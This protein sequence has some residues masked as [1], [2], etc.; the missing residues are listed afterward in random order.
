MNLRLAALAALPLLGSLS[1]G[2]F[3]RSYRPDPGPY[4]RI[5]EEAEAELVEA[6]SAFE[7]GELLDARAR[8]AALSERHPRCI[9]VGV[10]LQE[11][12]LLLLERGESVK[13]VSAP[14]AEEAQRALGDVYIARA[15]AEPTPA[16]EVLAA[17]LELDPVEALA[18]LATVLEL[19]RDCVWAHYATAH[20][21]ARLR[22]FPEARAALKAAFRQDGG[23][24]PSMRLHV[25][26]LANA[27]ATDDA[28]D[29]LER[30]LE[31]TEHDPLTD[32]AARADA[33][34][35][36]AALA[37]LSGDASEGLAILERL[38]HESL[39][40][41]ARAELVACAALEETGEREL[42]LSAARRAHD[43][44][45]DAL[46]GLVQQALLFRK[47]GNP[48]QE[49]AA[50]Q[51]VLDELEHRRAA[52][53]GSSS[54]DARAALDMRELLIELRARARLERLDRERAG[55][56]A[57]AAGEP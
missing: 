46:L 5:P 7:A 22:R 28:R 8:L 57:S 34:V 36:L 25:W 17:R 39:A 56:R 55:A 54:R 52:G 42:A 23:H 27:G 31:R 9:P 6:R 2:C 14:G 51:W 47:E 19:D 45:P 33:E 53:S 37:V 29:C 32:R 24:L 3:A 16:N 13:G 4:D 44:D 49:R 41:P 18:R 50:W 20:L 35:D 21:N 38:D 43:L 1:G 30:W 15:E 48:A 11:V 12:E 26:L 40:D 10:F